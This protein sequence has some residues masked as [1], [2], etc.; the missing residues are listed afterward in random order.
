MY[1]ADNG[2]AVDEIK[3]AAVSYFCAVAVS[4]VPGLGGVTV[5]RMIVGE[6]RWRRQQ[7]GSVA[8]HRGQQNTQS[9]QKYDQFFMAHGLILRSMAMELN[10]GT[11]G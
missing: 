3:T 2:Q 11:A 6:Y 5:G 10:R 7:Q 1:Q 8:E 9:D 4:T